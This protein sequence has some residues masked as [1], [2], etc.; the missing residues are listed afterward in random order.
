V[1]CRGAVQPGSLCTRRSRGPMGSVLRLKISLQVAGSG[2]TLQ[3][4]YIQIIDLDY[5]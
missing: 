3:K 4:Y 5:A 1:L 2:A